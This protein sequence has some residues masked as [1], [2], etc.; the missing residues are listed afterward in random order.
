[1]K[2][3]ISGDTELNSL[4]FL[5]R[6]ILLHN[7]FQIRNIQRL[8]LHGIN[9]PDIVDCLPISAFPKAKSYGTWKRLREEH[10]HLKPTEF[11]KQF[12]INNH[13]VSKAAKDTIDTVDSEIQ[14]LWSRML[15][16]LEHPEDWPT[17]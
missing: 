8:H 12:E 7:E 9:A 15:G 2:S 10:S 16:I 3:P 6:E 4:A 1:M 5:L 13:S 17:E 11:K 14:R